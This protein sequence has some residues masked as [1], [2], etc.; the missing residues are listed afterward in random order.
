MVVATS[1][2]SFLGI[3]S[4][5][6]A[7]LGVS[8]TLFVA[9]TVVASIW[10][11]YVTY[12]QGSYAESTSRR[13]DQS[14]HLI[15]RTMAEANEAQN[16]LVS[17]LEIARTLL[18]EIQC[19]VRDAQLAL[20]RQEVVKLRDKVVA[21][22]YV[23]EETSSEEVYNRHYRVFDVLMNL[24]SPDTVVDHVLH[25]GRE[26]N[27]KRGTLILESIRADVETLQNTQY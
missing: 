3:L 13:Y 23:T 6:I 19:S 11:I 5:V 21:S 10:L 17:E 25:L 22:G 9:L 16:V 15:Q 20:F 2:T 18:H 8:S 1:L 14:L 26:F 12:V 24:G 7:Y 27:N 4:F